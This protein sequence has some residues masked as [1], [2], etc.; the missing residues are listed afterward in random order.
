METLLNQLLQ[1][2]EK[3][4]TTNERFIVK[5]IEMMNEIDLIQLDLQQNDKLYQG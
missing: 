5:N 1:N 3:S 2:E 4:I